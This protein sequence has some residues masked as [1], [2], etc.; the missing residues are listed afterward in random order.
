[1]HR[2]LC[3]LL[4]V[5][6]CY[7]PH[8]VAGAPCGTDG[9][10]P[11][12]QVCIAGICQSPPTSTD[13]A[14]HESPRDGGVD[15]YVPAD[16]GVTDAPAQLALVQQSAKGATSGSPL[17]ITLPSLPAAGDVLI[18]LAGARQAR[19]P[20]SGVSGGGV[21]VWKLASRSIINCNEEIWY[22]TT[23]GTSAN[24]SI[25]LPDNLGVIFGHVSQWH[26]LTTTP[27]DMATA[28][29]AATSPAAPG[30][31]TTQHASDLVVL[32][33]SEPAPVTWGKPA[34]GTW[35]PLTPVTAGDCAHAAW[36]RIVTESGAYA[37]T[38][39]ES[40]KENWDAVVA[41]FAVAP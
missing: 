32:A 37:P 26:G 36:Y 11:L 41:A 30:T 4:P 40:G 21:S 31:I 29:S 5:S 10:C 7:S 34:P 6:G 12:E 17:M 33:A 15:V 18:V 27:L 9:Q 1:M 22:G 25:S 24:V 16:G 3:L 28:S 20:P 19:L 39:T 35:T 13:A 23:D 8:V 38:V 2:L 14:G